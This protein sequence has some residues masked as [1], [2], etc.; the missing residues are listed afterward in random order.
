MKQRKERQWICHGLYSIINGIKIPVESILKIRIC[1]TEQSSPARLIIR[2]TAT[3][4]LGC[5]N[6]TS[7][8]G[9]ADL[10]RMAVCAWRQSSPLACGDSRNIPRFRRAPPALKS[11]FILKY[12]NKN[13]PRSFHFYYFLYGISYL[14]EQKLHCLM[15]NL[16]KL[17]QMLQ[18]AQIWLLISGR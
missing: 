6:L 4:P 8:Q 14:I 17:C 10:R 16:Q 1:I 18:K 13:P 7:D 5:C 2:S 3:L 15:S 9:S 12:K 11:S